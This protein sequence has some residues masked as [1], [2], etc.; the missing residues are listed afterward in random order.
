MTLFFLLLAIGI[1][2]VS[3]V[4]ILG[5]IASRK[6]QFD[7]VSMSIVSLGVY[8][9]ICTLATQL[10]DAKTAIT[11]AGLLGLYESTI[12]WKWIGKFNA[13]FDESSEDIKKVV[14]EGADLPPKVVIAIV[15]VYMIIGWLVTLFV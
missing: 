14:D 5:A 3:V 9:I 11:L 13:Y 1:I 8:I 10:V 6:Y 15:L 12:A 2:S 4:T 7:F